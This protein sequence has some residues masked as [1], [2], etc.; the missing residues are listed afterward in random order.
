MI[1]DGHSDLLW[2]VTRRA[3]AG[4]DG[5][6]QKWVRVL[7][8]G[9]GE[10]VVLALWAHLTTAGA[11]WGKVPGM[12]HPRRRTERMLQVLERELSY[13]RD[14]RLVTSAAQAGEA[15]RAGAVY[16]FLS[17]EGMEAISTEVT[18]VDWYARQGVRMGMLT[19]NEDNLLASGAGG[20]RSRG[21][22]AA[23]RRV[24]RRME[25]VGMIVDVSHLND[26]GFWDVMGMAGKPV[27]ASHSNCRALCDVPRN[28]TD[29]Q[30]RAIR[31]SGGVVGLNA[32]HGFLHADPTRRTV[33][34]LALHAA[35]MA[36]VM[37]VEHVS[38]GFDFC[39]LFG[40]GGKGRQGSHGASHLEN[41]M[42]CLES[43]GMSRREREA[44]ARENLLRV[45]A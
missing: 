36:E 15:R 3:E 7:R 5:A 20:D 31:D 44:I 37:G 39:G 43:L 17:V 27:M 26:R 16:A 12:G 22:T 40:P 19:W 10:G 41:P 1:F 45:L 2:D 35:H 30:L 4:E 32:Y 42:L 18:G 29:D 11:F 25:E 23:G 14:L 9:G 38:C 21:L 28:L 13:T 6:L 33:E 24:I 34:M 8:R